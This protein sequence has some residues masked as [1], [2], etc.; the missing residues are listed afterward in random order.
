[1]FACFSC[2]SLRLFIACDDIVCDNRKS[3]LQRR[4]FHFDQQ[5]DIS[6]ELPTLDQM[7]SWFEPEFVLNFAK[8]CLI[9]ILRVRTW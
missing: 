8:F 7:W 9:T 1:M 2:S 6:N 3:V 4:W 5:R